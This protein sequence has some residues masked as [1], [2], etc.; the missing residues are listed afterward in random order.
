MSGGEDWIDELD[1][2]KASIAARPPGDPEHFGA[3]LAPGIN[4]YVRAAAIVLRSSE[5]FLRSELD[6]HA[7]LF[8]DDPDGIGLDLPAESLETTA[9]NIG[10]A[11]QLLERLAAAQASE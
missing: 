2:L 6:E 5:R 7:R 3:W 1:A 10:R 11:A 4:E 8:G 9:R